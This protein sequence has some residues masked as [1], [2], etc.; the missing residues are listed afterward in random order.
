MKR[1]TK[2][3]QDTKELRKDKNAPAPLQLVINLNEDQL[4]KLQDEL[5][6]LGE[7]PKVKEFLEINKMIQSLRSSIRNISNK[8]YEAG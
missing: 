1:K 4:K 7:I 2:E 6:V 3:I 5:E 8:R